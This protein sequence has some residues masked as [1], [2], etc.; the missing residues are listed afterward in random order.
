MTEPHPNDVRFCVPAGEAESELVIK[1]SVFI[2]SMARARTADDAAAFVERVRQAYPDANHHAWAYRITGGPQAQ[3]GSSDDGEPGGTAGR[4][5]L[6]V[7][8]GRDLRQVVAVGTRYFGGVKLGTGGLV[9]AYGGC[10][11]AAL[12][13]LPIVELAYHRLA[14]ITIDYTLYGNLSYLLPRHGVTIEEEVFADRATLLL[15]IPPEQEQAVAELLRELTNGRTML[16]TCWEGGH[17]VEFAQ[18]H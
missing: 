7:L 18:G 16:A 9:R 4:P 3:I 17:Y 13:E 2:G 15:S 5:M 1:N 10:V 8:E 14:R 6:A 12:Q 11:R